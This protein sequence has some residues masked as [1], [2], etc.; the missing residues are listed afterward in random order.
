MITDRNAENIA[1]TLDLIAKKI[2]SETGKKIMITFSIEDDGEMYIGGVKAGDPDYAMA[3]RMAVG[4]T[5]F[6]SDKYGYGELDE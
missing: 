1:D 4:M 5:G 2:H 6:I 3:C